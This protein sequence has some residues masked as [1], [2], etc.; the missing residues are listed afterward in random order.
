MIQKN[1]WLDIRAWSLSQNC[2]ENHTVIRNEFL[3]NF[4]FGKRLTELSETKPR[5]MSLFWGKPNHFHN[6]HIHIF[7]NAQH[8]QYIGNNDDQ[9]LQRDWM[10][11][12]PQTNTSSTTSTTHSETSTTGTRTTSTLSSVTHTTT[13]LTRST[14]TTSSSSSTTSSTSTSSTSSSTSVTETTTSRTISSTSKTSTTTT[15]KTSTSTS[16]TSVSSTT[17]S[18]LELARK[19]CF[20]VSLFRTFLWFSCL[21]C[22]SRL[23]TF[24]A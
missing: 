8:I 17:S 12:P 5:F 9:H 10:K 11:I 14:T 7:N 19:R 4:R 13:S 3:K 2:G 20:C 15:S 21:L 24:V 22:G 1:P 18:A 23:S 16:S 6:S